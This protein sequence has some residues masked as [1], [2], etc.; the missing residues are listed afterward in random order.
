MTTETLAQQRGHA[1]A[2]QMNPDM[3][4]VLTARYGNLLPNMADTV[5]KFAYGEFYSRPGLDLKTRYVATIAALAAQGGQTR[6]QLKINIS[7]GRKAGLTQTEIAEII[8][9]MA[10]Y[11]G[12]PAAI[13][14]LNTA[15][16]AFAAE[17]Q[18]P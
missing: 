16:E 17:T 8:W 13:N 11:G 12:L 15:L 1:L 14:A 9:Q 5:E 3:H 4:K 7:A 18:E 2:E 6:P 10:L